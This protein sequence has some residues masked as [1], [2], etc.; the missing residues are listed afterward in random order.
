M[1]REQLKTLT[2]PMYYLLLALTKSQHGYSIMQS[3]QE[4]SGGR[5]Q[6]GAGTLYALLGRFES[7]KIIAQV[8]AHDRKKI[9]ALT[10]KGRDMLAAEYLRLNRMAE[11]GRHFFRSDG[12]VIPQ[13]P[14][15]EQSL[16]ACAVSAGESQENEKTAAPLDSPA[17]DSP[18]TPTGSDPDTQPDSDPSLPDAP[19]EVP[20]TSREGESRPRFNPGFRRQ[21]PAT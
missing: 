10:D 17:A 4:I 7:E 9:Y 12:T 1:A 16:A 11:D 21:L 19:G 20:Q 15:V 18:D 8:A 13:E 6:V 5:V 14:S 2:E 3:I